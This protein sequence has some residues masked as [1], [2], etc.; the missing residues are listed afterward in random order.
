MSVPYIF[1]TVPGG[2]SIP[3]EHLDA[4]FAYITS[5]NPVFQNLTVSGNIAIDGT[6]TVDGLTT[7]NGGLTLSGPLTINGMTVVPTG[8]TGTGLLVFNTGPTL[9]APIL[10]TPASGTLTNC[11]GLPV[12]TGISGLGTGVATWLA[13]P[14]S[15]NLRTAVLDPTGTGNLVFSNAP[16]IN[17]ASLTSPALGVPVSGSLGSCTGYLTSNL[18]GTVP[19]SQ[20]VQDR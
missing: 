12:L 1:S 6:A 9:V 5:G 11:T 16:L 20:G 2:S 14:S 18:V 3:L 13:T 17:N 8:I 19:I 4:N 7:L 15:A 10:G